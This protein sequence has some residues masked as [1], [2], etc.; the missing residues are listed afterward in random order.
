[1]K[2]LLFIFVFA[3]LACVVNGQSR[4]KGTTPFEYHPNLT[5]DRYNQRIT[6]KTIPTGPEQ[7]VILSR[8]ADGSYAVEQYQAGLKKQ[9]SATIPLTPEQTV[10]GF[11]TSKDAAIVVAQT[12]T[13]HTQ[14][15]YGYYV[16]LVSGALKDKQ[17]LLE[18][19]VSNREP[20]VAFSQD[21]SKLLVYHTQADSNHRIR[22]ISGSLYDEK[23]S[24]IKDT[25]YN[26]NDV[27]D[28]LSVD[29]Q[30]NN[31]GDQH[32]S[33]IS[34]NMN[35]LT[36]RQYN[37]K[38]PKAKI[39]SVL[40]G[41]VFDGKKV[42]IM[43]SR[44]KLMSDGQLYGA[45][46]TAEETSGLYHSLKTV[47]FNFEAEDMVFAEE[48]KFTADYLAKINGLNKTDQNKPKRFEDIYLSDIYQAAD[49][50]IIVL[51][52]KKYTTGG[53]NAPYFAKEMLLFA[54]D[55]YMNSAWSSVLMKHQ[56][57]SAEDVFSGISYSAYMNGNTLSLLTLEE[58]EGKY[59][60]YLRQ[61]DTKT[62]ETTPAKGV[63][64]NVANDKELAYVKDFTA[65]F[66]D[67]DVT[68]VVR[69]KKREAGLRLHHI[70]LK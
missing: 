40:V 25:N 16:E 51:A 11:Y 70:Q 19:P 42:Y 48:F 4:T 33:L 57:A 35:R 2:N 1:M 21:G 15:L 9:W 47:R 58:L 34:D 36:V 44:F 20:G 29:V 61:I 13:G 65:W 5:E 24:K 69:P 62:G 46:I 7:F 3:L 55:E 6:N 31:A 56:Q 41:G 52:E 26:L 60:L 49:N 17:L 67:K 50:Q 10:Y 22:S 23:L 66:S 18:S 53:K 39:M 30:L 68:V 45:V 38:D 43:D 12:K 63:R 14:Q 27:R 59:D 32:L 37:L 64:L 28:I 8:K 54:Y